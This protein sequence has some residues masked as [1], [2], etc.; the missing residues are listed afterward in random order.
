MVQT[1]DVIQNDHRRSQFSIPIEAIDFGLWAGACCAAPGRP[2][3]FFRW[4]ICAIHPP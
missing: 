2:F 4:L 1:N 3:C